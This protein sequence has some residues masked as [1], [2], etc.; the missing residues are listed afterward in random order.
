MERRRGRRRG[1]VASRSGSTS[2]MGW[3]RVGRRGVELGSRSASPS[4]V[5]RRPV[6]VSWAGRSACRSGLSR[7]GRARVSVGCRSGS[8]WAFRRCLGGRAV[9]GSVGVAAGGV[10]VGVPVGVSRWACRSG[11]RPCSCGVSVGLSVGVC[12]RVG[13]RHEPV[14]GQGG[15][16]LA[17]MRER[18]KVSVLM[19]TADRP[20]ANPSNY[21]TRHLTSQSDQRPTVR[22]RHCHSAAASTRIGISARTRTATATRA[23]RT[24][25]FLATMPV[26]IRALP[27]RTTL[28]T[29]QHQCRASLLVLSQ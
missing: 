15:S 7:P 5:G 17:A 27:M 28:R 19:T 10:S 12:R 3:R 23:V 2:G 16:A 8:R 6:G 1:A 22:P 25:R 24:S 20:A 26:P 18:A 9:G 14:A 4:C 11:R 13:R 29:V 21:A